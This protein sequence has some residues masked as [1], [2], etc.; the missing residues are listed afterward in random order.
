MNVG[1]CPLDS[2]MTWS[3]LLSVDSGMALQPWSGSA[4]SEAVGTLE[5]HCHGRGRSGSVVAIM[6]CRLFYKE[7]DR[8]LKE[9]LIN[10]INNQAK[11]VET[12]RAMKA[13]NEA[14]KESKDFQAMKKKNKSKKNTLD[15][16][17]ASRRKY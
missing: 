4:E 11:R 7:E 3:V 14:T 2:R 5:D 13:L 9:Q 16:T 17:K 10:G 12:Q 8:I 1:G 15:K 6:G